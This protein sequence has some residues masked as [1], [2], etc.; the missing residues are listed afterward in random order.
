MCTAMSAGRPPKPKAQKIKEGTYRKDRDLG[1]T[2]AFTRVVKIPEPPDHFS[3]IGKDVWRTICNEMISMEL[4]QTVDV[5]QLEIL[6][7]E[8]ETYHT[9]RALL[10]GQYVVPTPQG[11]TKQNPLIN[12]ANVALQNVIRIAANFGLSPA[13]RMRLK[14]HNPE[15]KAAANPAIKLITQARAPIPKVTARKPATTSNRK[16]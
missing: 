4:L 6:I 14:L 16:K 12:I 1:D 15:K 8:L 7:T 2:L 3:D 10:N 11:G 5:F 9:S 13:A